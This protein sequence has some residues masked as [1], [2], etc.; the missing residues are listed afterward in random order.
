MLEETQTPY[1]GS[2][3]VLPELFLAGEYPG[4]V[5]P[6]MTSRRLR[7]LVAR[8]I[9]TFIDLTDEDEVSEDAKVIPPYR[10]IL[11]QISE[12]ESVQTTYANIPVED[13]GVPSPWTYV[14]FLM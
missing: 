7:G 10:S 4:E 5:D 13:R 2:Y 1:P 14:A 8:G 9:R 3:W 6:E 11:R 12:T